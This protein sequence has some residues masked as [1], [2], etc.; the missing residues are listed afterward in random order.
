MP[1]VRV[2][3]ILPRLLELWGSLTPVRKGMLTASAVGLVVAAFALSSWAGRVDYAT[4]YTDLDS[5]DSGRIVEDLRT[6]GI[7]YEIDRSGATI[8][9]PQSHVDELRVD[10]ASRGL[11]EGGQVGFELFEGNAFTATDF[12][13]RLNYQRG[14]QG[15]L[16]R[17][18]STFPAVERVR[19]HIVMPERSLFVDDQ[20]PATASVVLGL[21]AGRSLAQNEVNGIA[22]LVAGAVEG[23]EKKSITIL[24][25]RGS[26]IYD[27]ATL[28]SDSGI[29]LTTTQISLQQEYEARVEANVQSM[30]DRALG[31]AKSA[32]SV[33]AL[34]NF[35]RVE[36]ERETYS[37]PESGTPRSSSSVTETYTTG[38]VEGAGQIP[39]ALTNIPGANANL[40]AVEPASGDGAGTTYQRSETTSNFELDRT[41]TRQVGTPGRVERLSVS[42]LLDDTVSEELAQSLSASVA[43]AAGVDAERG[44]AVV[45]TRVAFDRS[46]VDE[47]R[48]AFEADASRDQL[49]GY[50][51]M[52]LPVL[53]LLFGFIFVRMLL[54]SLG[55]RAVRPYDLGYATGGPALLGAGAGGGNVLAEVGDGVGAAIRALPQ[56]IEVRHTELERSIERM[57]H[58]NPEGIAEV[59]QAWMRED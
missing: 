4:L 54:K 52:A 26:I 35:D 9:V 46:A 42:L 45:V 41:V 34:M 22:H 8:R 16:E 25:Q 57:A 28:D 5:A 38:T 53:V 20:Q 27:G 7:P 12:V 13:Q 40:P 21:R 47:A 58:Q 32:V 31:P 50:V 48:A 1:G 56:P 44:D 15:E 6:R 51:R 43:A 49:M 2:G 10:F 18:I 37:A 19:V 36:T 39:G 55:S 30:L 17:T 14:L 29:G 11:P 33:S 23:L 3:Q 59:V 24:D